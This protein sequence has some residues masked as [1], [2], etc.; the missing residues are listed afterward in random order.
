M[1]FHRSDRSSVIDLTFAT[2]KLNKMCI[3]WEIS[4]DKASGSDHEIILFSIN[5]DSRNL[6][7]NPVYSNHYNF[8]KADWKSFAENLLRESNKQEYQSSLDNSEISTSLLEMEAEKLRDIIF[9]AAETSIPKKKISEKLKPWWTSE[10]KALRKELAT[11][12]RYWKRKQ[13]NQQEFQ[14]K[15]AEYLNKIKLAKARCWNKFLENATG[16]DIFKAFQYTKFRRNEKLPVLEYEY[17]SQKINTVNFKE[18]CSAFLRVLFKKPP[19]STAVSWENYT[20]D[21]SWEW[22]ELAEDEIKNAILTSSIKKA[23]GPD[24]ISFLIVQKAFETIKYRF[25]SLYQKLIKYRYHPVCWKE[26][27]RVILKKAGRK[28]SIPKSYRVVSLLNCLGKIS[29]KIVATRLAYLANTTNILYF[30]QLGG[31][32]QT[33][34]V[35]AAMSLV[36]DIQLAKHEGKMTSA[37]FI[38]I[39][40]A[41]DHVSANQLLKICQELGLP[42]NLCFWIE[43]FLRNRSIQLAF[44]GEKQEKTQVEIGIPQGSPVSPILFLIYIRDLFSGIE[45]IEVRKPSYVDDIGLIA[46]STSLERN[47]NILQNAAERLFQAGSSRLVQ[48]DMEKTE[49][50]YFY[51]KRF[52]KN[53]D[54][55]IRLQDQIIEPKSLV[56]WLGFWF[57]SKLSFKK[58]VEIKIANATRVFHQIARLSNTERGLSFQAIRQLYIACITSVA[59]YGVPIWWNNQKFLLDK[60]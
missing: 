55:S 58:H 27:V 32:K 29:E 59:D 44:D 3:N 16:K 11:T 40:G 39:K 41:Y 34:A 25:I 48:F 60:F 37:L 42:K 53:E 10:L 56:K 47:C 57:D 9:K 22:P 31:R 38:D 28:A 35:D 12:K 14:R 50:I 21:S 54:F 46:S 13:Q 24:G 7:E 26:A 6:V 4:E 8:D 1:T 18:K 43:S 20:E 17:E 2:K 52:I 30:D 19:Q 5:I 15:K 51:L 23:A 49:L 36:H 33:S 45:G